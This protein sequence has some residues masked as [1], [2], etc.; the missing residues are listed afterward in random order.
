MAIGFGPNGNVTISPEVIRDALLSLPEDERMFV[1]SDP[2]AGE[3]R[4]YE[5]HRS[6][7]GNLEYES[8]VEPET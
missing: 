6:V 3:R 1:V 7:A 2:T 8:K 5:F 4:I